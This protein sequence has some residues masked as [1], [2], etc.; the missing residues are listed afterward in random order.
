[1]IRKHLRFRRRIFIGLAFASL[2]A[3]P[4]AQAS[5]GFY[6]DG[7]PAPRSDSSALV[8]QSSPITS[9]NTAQPLSQLQ[10]EAMRWQAMADAYQTLA[11]VRSENSFGSGGPSSVHATSP[12]VSAS[13]S[14]GSSDGFKW[15]DA[16]I[17]ASVAFGVALLLLISVFIG[18]RNRDR[19]GLAS[20]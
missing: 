1:M 3:A 13:V 20:A 8:V 14:G 16:G 9:E 5:T 17:G 10:V 18:R 19:T 15:D 2:V 4:A 12:Q 7:G 6:V 11:P